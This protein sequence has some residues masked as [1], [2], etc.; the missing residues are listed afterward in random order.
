M[1]I[2][3]FRSLTRPRVVLSHSHWRDEASLAAWR[4]DSKHHAAQVAGRQQ[5]FEDYRLRIAQLVCECLPAS[6]LRR[7]ETNGA[8][9]DP[10]LRPERFL[11]AA[12]A[13]SPMEVDGDGEVFASVSRER[14]YLIL[15]PAP[16][17]EHGV[18]LLDRLSRRRAR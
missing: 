13:S 7:S 14:E 17:G 9:N 2:D 16:S 5:H 1:F 15:R 3:R 12:S 10:E 8:Y 6:G 18:S 11:I 4:S